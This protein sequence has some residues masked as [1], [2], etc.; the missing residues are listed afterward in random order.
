MFV[1]GIFTL[2][3]NLKCIYNSPEHPNRFSRKQVS[4]KRNLSVGI[5]TYLA[6]TGL[7]AYEIFLD[8]VFLFGCKEG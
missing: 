6:D 4:E 2:F 7:L 5:R 1:N 8:G 3:T